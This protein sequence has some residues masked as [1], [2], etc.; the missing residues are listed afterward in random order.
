[1][2]FFKTS[3]FACP[4]CGVCEMDPEVQKKID[5]IRERLGVPLHLNSAYRCSAHNREVGGKTASQHL[6]GKAIDVSI[7]NMTAEKRR[8][9]LELALTQFWG[10][11]I[12][13]TFFHLDVGEP[14]LWVY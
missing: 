13:P 2:K 8:Q 10:I 1:M 3:E 11:G 4:C 7:A 5:F 9:F 6:Q 12:A 14:R